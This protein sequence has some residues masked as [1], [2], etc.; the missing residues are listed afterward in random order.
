MA[1][2]ATFHI[3]A[4]DATRSGFASVQSSLSRIQKSAKTISANLGTMFG[5]TVAIA[6]VQKL[7]QAL[8]SVETNAKNYGLSAEE[9]ARVTRSTGALDEGAKQLKLG[10][11]NA[12]TAMLELKDSVLGVDKVENIN[13]AEKVMAERDI[14]KIKEINE[15]FADLTRSTMALGKSDV[16]K[17]ITIGE[18]IKKIGSKVDLPSQS[19][20]LNSAQRRFEIE[21]LLNEQRQISTSMM[22]EGKNLEKDLSEAKDKLNASTKTEIEQ[23]K[24]IVSGIEYYQ[25]VV[26]SLTQSMQ[27]FY[28]KKTGILVLDEESIGLYDAQNIAT[29]EL[30]RLIG[31]RKIAETDFQIIAKNTGDILSS[32]FED[33]I[34]SGQKL[35]EVIK[36]L[37]LDLVRMV[38]QQTVT[39]PMAAGVSSFLQNMFKASG[40]PVSSGS[41]YVVGEKG[42][43]LFVPNSSGSI[44]PNSK[45]GSGSSGAGGTNVNVTYNIASGVSRSDLA[46]ILEQQRKL[47]KA[48]IPDMVRRGGGYRA[49]FA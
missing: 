42:P 31:L 3:R 46:P 34:F 26:D 18:E 32:G 1:A 14:P 40:G 13:L 39:T 29:K 24:D 7:N 10:I 16:S 47:L 30:I 28:D 17:F 27:E 48:E 12:V 5:A 43:E 11:A 2:E 19:A 15:A 49:A 38:F 20:G 23:Q 9:I 44:I 6:G 25:L 33:A 45:M 4:V 22:E 37:G 35:R 21:K 36:A 41:P 8:E